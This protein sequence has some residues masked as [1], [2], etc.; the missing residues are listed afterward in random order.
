MTYLKNELLW[1]LPPDICL[2]FCQFW[3]FRWFLLCFIIVSCIVSFFIGIIVIFFRWF[4]FI[5]IGFLIIF[6]TMS[7]W[8]PP[9]K[10]KNSML[11][12]QST[13]WLTELKLTDGTSTIGAFPL[14][15]LCHH[16]GMSIIGA[17]PVFWLFHLF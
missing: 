9:L 4:I 13:K 16:D 3:C 8:S 10:K 15:W 12:L 2:W 17:F 6:I 14:C 5:W 11:L 1:P 7:C